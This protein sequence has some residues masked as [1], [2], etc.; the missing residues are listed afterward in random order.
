[1]IDTRCPVPIAQYREVV[2]TVVSALADAAELTDREAALGRA[3]TAF[4]DLDAGDRV[5]I[6]PLAQAVARAESGAWAEPLRA[7]MTPDPDAALR[8]QWSGLSAEQQDVL[9]PVARELGARVAADAR[10]AASLAECREHHAG[11]FQGT[12]GQGRLDSAIFA[13][14][15]RRAVGMRTEATPEQLLARFGLESF[16]PGQREAVQ[17][18]LDGRS[19][20]LALPTG[21]GKSLCY[22][23]PAIASDAL[24]VVVSPLIALIADQHQ[25][26]ADLGVRSTMLASTLGAETNRAALGSVA[27]DAQIVFC[28]PERFASGAFRRALSQRRI[29]LFVVD[30]A[31]CVSEWGHDFRPDY[32]RLRP[33]IDELGRPPVMAATA[34]A[35]PKVAQEI[36]ERLG[37]EDPVLVRRGFDRPN[38]S[39]DTVAFSG[40]GAVARKRATLLSGLRDP[41][42]R[43]AIV[44]CGTR[45]DTEQLTGE[46]RADG[47]AAVGYHAGLSAEQRSGAQAAFTTAQADVIVATNAFGM[48]VDFPFGVRSV[49]HWAMPVSVEAYYQEAGRAGRDGRPARA[50][51]LAMRGDLGRLVQFIRNAELG[52]LDV[53]RTLRRLR[54][55]AQDGVASIDARAQEDRDRIALAVAERC[56]AVSLAPGPGGTVAVSLWGEL[57][58]GRAQRVCREATGRRW[59]AYQALKAFATSEEV[60]RRQQLLDHFGDPTAPAATGRCCDL[61]DPLDWLV[62]ADRA[63]AKRRGATPAVPSGPPVDAAAFQA[64]KSWRTERADGKPAYTVAANAVL[65]ELLRQHPGDAA[66]LLTIKGIGP[67]FV[68]KH[69]ESLLALLSDLP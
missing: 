16:R 49:W 40:D 56:G 15:G 12:G 14:A 39:F 22:Q 27:A 11:G 30:E 24:T 45:K 53:E 65:E 20:L 33:I 52:P 62:V 64:L 3:R 2:I 63:P 18:A 31:H 47:L 69:G 19:C 41:A 55:V 5:L 1:M 13:D 32:L 61:C 6:T 26:L 59:D 35:T 8:A 28:A 36:V 4:R 29:G 38:I 51:M 57:D 23:L 46:L 10:V 43:P 17:A 54:A 42:N 37:M 58:S 34:T 25:R 21:A 9:R 44:Y 50:V 66:G 48:G 67:A 68:A 7:L 60:C